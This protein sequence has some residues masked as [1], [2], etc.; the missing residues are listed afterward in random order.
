MLYQYHYE[1]DGHAEGECENELKA[2]G[3]C[4]PY[5]VI[6]DTYYDDYSLVVV[7]FDIPEN[8]D[9]N[10]PFTGEYTVYRKELTMIIR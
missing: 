2:I 7:N 10:L 6:I 3:A 4:N 1:W 8:A 5:C 9:K